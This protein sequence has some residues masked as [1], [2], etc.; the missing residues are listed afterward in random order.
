MIHAHA[1]SPYKV[2]R[3]EKKMEPAFED[4]QALRLL[5]AFWQIKDGKAREAI[6]TAA[7]QARNAEREAAE[8][9]PTSER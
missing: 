3:E 4:L 5:R 6:V 2:V 7:E 9:Q 1:S 8:Q